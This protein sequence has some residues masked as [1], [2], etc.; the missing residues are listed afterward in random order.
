MLAVIEV[1]G[2]YNEMDTILGIYHHASVEGNLLTDISYANHVS[3]VG[4]NEGAESTLFGSAYKFIKDNRAEFVQYGGVLG[5]ALYLGAEMG[6]PLYKNGYALLDSSASYNYKTESAWNIGIEVGSLALGPVLKGVGT[7]FRLARSGYRVFKAGASYADDVFRYADDVYSAGRMSRRSGINVVDY[8]GFGS[9]ASFNETDLLTQIYKNKVSMR[10][11]QQMNDHG[12]DI[13]FKYDSGIDDL[14]AY[15]P[16]SRRIELYPANI[17]A[18]ALEL[19]HDPAKYAARIFTHE[20]KHVRR[21]ALGVLTETRYDEYLANTREYL[22]QF[23]RRPNLA[24]RGRIWQNVS[25]EYSHLDVGKRP[26]G[27]WKSFE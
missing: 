24:E 6:D 22:F 16:N 14:A 10:S 9:T 3:L 13:I 4:S 12:V 19:G 1:V 7:G 5:G 21:D 27:W 18:A 15:Y 23:G 26:V 8:D 17:E 11:Y 25:S 2:S 20:A